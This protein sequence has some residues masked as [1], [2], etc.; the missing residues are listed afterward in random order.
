[1]HTISA[2]EL[3]FDQVDSLGIAS[4]LIMNENVFEKKDPTDDQKLFNLPMIDSSLFF[5]YLPSGKFIN[6]TPTQIP[7]EN[8]KFVALG[9]MQLA[10]GSIETAECFCRRLVAFQTWGVGEWTPTKPMPL[11]H[12]THKPPGLMVIPGTNCL[13][14]Y[15]ECGRILQSKAT[16]QNY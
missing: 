9:F 8:T 1:L 2:Y 11:T 6:G 5:F 10:Y 13:V 3:P 15:M 4:T 7:T 16:M 14:Q 12:E